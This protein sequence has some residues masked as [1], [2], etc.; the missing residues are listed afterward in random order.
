MEWVRIGWMGNSWPFYYF[1]PKSLV[2]RK[3]IDFFSRCSKC[4]YNRL[5]LETTTSFKRRAAFAF[6]IEKISV[7][8]YKNFWIRSALRNTSIIDKTRKKGCEKCSRK[9]LSNDKFSVEACKKL[10]KKA[11]TQKLLCAHKWSVNE[12]IGFFSAAATTTA[13]LSL[14]FSFSFSYVRAHLLPPLFVVARSSLT[15]WKPL[16]YSKSLWSKG[17]LSVT[18]CLRYM[19][20]FPFLFLLWR[21]CSLLTITHIHTLTHRY[22]SRL[23]DTC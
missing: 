16:H 2:K 5:S 17:R 18:I 21:R 15:L 8:S 23:H 13:V 20:P 22:F 14:Y 3:E 7:N 9:H 4:H 1:I 12:W 19:I 10:K 6:R 11:Y